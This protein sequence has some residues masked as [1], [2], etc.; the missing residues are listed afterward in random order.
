M[1]KT[2]KNKMDKK[3]VISHQPQKNS[4]NQI[5]NQKIEETS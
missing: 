1:D 2:T 4:E 3:N 5:K